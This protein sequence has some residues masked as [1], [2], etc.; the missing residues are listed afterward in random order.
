MPPAL[1]ALIAQISAWLIALLLVRAG[2]LAPEM[3]FVVGAQALGA[4]AV[5]ALLRSAWWW[6]PIHLGFSPLLI[7]ADQ[8]GISP[9]WYLLAFVVLSVVFWSSFRTQVPLY[10]SNGQTVAALLERLPVDRS[11]RFLDIGSG[12][13]SVLIPLARHRPDCRFAGIESAPGPYLVS[14]LMARGIANL[15]IERGDFFKSSWAGQDIVYAFLSPVPM[16]K[17]WAKAGHELTSDA[18]LISNSFEIPGVTAEEVIHLDDS[19]GTTLFI[20]RPGVQA[21]MKHSN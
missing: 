1:K 14:R 5:A 2:L 10:L 16:S 15:S 4:M 3:H 9:Q 19:R 18:L 11:A 8:L 20:Y 6:L 12:T 13:G 17:V 7:A 21:S